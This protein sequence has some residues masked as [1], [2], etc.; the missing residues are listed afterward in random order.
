GQEGNREQAALLHFISGMQMQSIT[1]I[2]N[3]L[4][5]S[6]MLPGEKLSLNQ[7]VYMQFEGKKDNNGNIDSDFC[8]ILFVLE[9]EK[10][11]ETMIDMQI[12]KR[13]IS[14]NIYNEQ[15]EPSIV[16]LLIPSFEASL[17]K[18][19]YQLSAV[20]WKQLH[21]RTTSTNKQTDNYVLTENRDR[22]RYDFLI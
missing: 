14:V 10:M 20:Q 15:K 3:A 12:Q 9:L 8:R 6:F 4:Q 11:N 1:E 7:D 17:D 21:D 13:I 16:E 22:E 2:N 19:D 5:A 18:V